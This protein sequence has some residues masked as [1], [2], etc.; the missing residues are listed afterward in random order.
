MLGYQGTK[1]G[2]GAAYADRLRYETAAI[3]VDS[4]RLPL[5]EKGA[6]VSWS[7]LEL[8]LMAIRR[9]KLLANVS[10]FSFSKSKVICS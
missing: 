4:L 9:R 6:L 3:D 1:Q 2:Y 10:S 5:S 8:R 7:G